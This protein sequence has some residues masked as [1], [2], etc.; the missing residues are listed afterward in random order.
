MLQLTQTL[1]AWGTPAC[2]DTLKAEFEALD[3]GQL[4]LQQG[5]AQSSYVS[6]D[7][8]RVMIISLGERD[9]TLLAKLGIFYSGII[10][11]CNCADDPTPVD[12]NPEY[13]VIEIGIDKGNGEATLSLASD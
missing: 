5:L 10:A 8:F 12:T 7:P 3:A 2:K 6:D 11:G 1:K 9:G 4:P 13:C